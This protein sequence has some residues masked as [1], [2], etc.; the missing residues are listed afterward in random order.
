MTE[1]TEEGNLDYPTVC[2]FRLLDYLEL[3][4]WTGKVMRDDKR[5]AMAGELPPIL[6]RL[7]IAPDV[8]LRYMRPRV[9]RCLVAIGHRERLRSYAVT[10]GRKRKTGTGTIGSFSMSQRSGTATD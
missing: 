2:D 8:W 4:D 1:K 6:S 5:G 7:Q 10:T 9:N 3:V